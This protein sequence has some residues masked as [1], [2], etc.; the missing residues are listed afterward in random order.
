MTPARDQT[1][2]VRSDDDGIEQSDVKIPIDLFWLLQDASVGG[3]QANITYAEFVSN[4]IYRYLP[5]ETDEF[6][7]RPVRSG[8]QKFRIDLPFRLKEEVRNLAKRRKSLRKQASRSG[9]SHKA[10]KYS[11]ARAIFEELVARKLAVECRELGFSDSDSE[12]IMRLTGYDPNDALG[13]S[14]LRK[15]R[16]ESDQP[17]SP[18]RGDT[19]PKALP[20]VN[21][22]RLLTSHTSPNDQLSKSPEAPARPPAAKKKHLKK[23]NRKK[24][25]AE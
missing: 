7:E 11:S 13:L 14:K 6:A 19:P 24:R 15:I 21:G 4:A 3:Q 2:L 16:S 8:M 1:P 22:E 23:P 25:E 18:E 9:N 17:T 12:R 5:A 10:L 20:P